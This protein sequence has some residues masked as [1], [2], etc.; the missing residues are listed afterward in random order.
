MYEMS[1]TAPKRHFKQLDNATVWKQQ[2]LGDIAEFNPKTTVPSEFEYVDLASVTGITMLSHRSEKKESAPASAQRLAR[3][4]D[5]FYQVVRPYQKNNYLYNLP[6]NNYVF[7]TGYAQLRPSVDSY[8]LFSL[9]QNDR[10]VKL[11]VDRCTGSCYPTINPNVLGNIEVRVPVDINLQIKIGQLFKALDELITVQQRKLE[12]ILLLKKAYLCEMFPTNEKNKPKRRFCGFTDVW[13]QRI[14][15]DVILSEHKGTAQA[16]MVGTKS[17]YL[18]ASYLNG[19]PISYVDAAIDVECDD[20]LVLWDG[21]AA[22]TVY[23]GLTGAL[24]STLKAYKPKES[25]K[26][27]YQFLKCNQQMIFNSYRIPNIPHVV[28]TFAMEFNVN[29]PSLDEQLKIGA[30]FQSLD[31]LIAFQQYKLE[32]LHNLKE[33][34]LNEVFC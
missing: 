3:Q 7:S 10:F 28:K 24:G 26:F 19:G 34:Y 13:R 6:Y 5:I 29:I 12:K 22:G 18:D 25:G 11:V 17:V 21:S 30:F 31:S 27:L 14:L 4:G 23:Q 16:G 20:I 1:L 8:F 32:K 33:A 9:L 15:Q 2:K